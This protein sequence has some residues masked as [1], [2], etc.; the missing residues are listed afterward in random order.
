MTKITNN[1]VLFPSSFTPGRFHEFSRDDYSKLEYLPQSSKEPSKDYL[2]DLRLLET[3]TITKT[4]MVEMNL[5]TVVPHD[6]SCE[7]SG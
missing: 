6:S 5:Y 4:S 2:V 3:K 7:A 1:G